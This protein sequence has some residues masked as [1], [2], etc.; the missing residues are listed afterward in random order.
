[1]NKRQYNFLKSKYNDLKISGRYIFAI[2]NGVFIFPTYISFDDDFIDFF[3]NEEM[4]VRVF[5]RDVINLYIRVSDVDEVDVVSGDDIIS[6]DG[7]FIES[8]KQY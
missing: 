2:V 4:L 1:M 3:F 8:Y 7:S 5:Y 6:Y